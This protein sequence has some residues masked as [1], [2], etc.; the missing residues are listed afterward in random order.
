MGLAGLVP[1]LCSR[2]ITAVVQGLQS[3]HFAVI[4]QYIFKAHKQLLTSFQMGKLHN[5]LIPQFLICKTE[6]HISPLGLTLV[7]ITEFETFKET[8][9]KPLVFLLY[10]KL[11]H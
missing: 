8:H 6:T 7:L 10:I 2:R 9:E 5:L 4:V 1:Y 11:F 3:F